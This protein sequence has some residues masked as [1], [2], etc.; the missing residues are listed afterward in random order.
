M[1][2]H[3]GHAPVSPALLPPFFKDY[4]PACD[5]LCQPNRIYRYYC[6]VS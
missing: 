6:L 1:Q 5:R 4:S 2:N 3:M